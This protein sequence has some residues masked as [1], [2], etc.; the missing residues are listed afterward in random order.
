MFT[1]TIKN[2]FFKFSKRFNFNNFIYFFLQKSVDYTDKKKIQLYIKMCNISY[3]HFFHNCTQFK[4][5]D[6]FTNNILNKYI[7]V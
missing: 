4:L 7:Y 1:K 5:G 2:T 6:K 3:L